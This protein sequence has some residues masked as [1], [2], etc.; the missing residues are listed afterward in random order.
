MTAEKL[1]KDEVAERLQ[2]VTTYVRD[3]ERRVLQGDIMDLQG[4][5]NN[6][7]QIC[8]DIAKLPQKDAQD[9]DEPMQALIADLE[10]LANAMRA[11][12]DQY[13]DE[14]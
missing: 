9:L 11:H 2:A 5:D 4:L 3:C 1:D 6:V 12:D 8:E 10:K 13:G 14:T 7:L